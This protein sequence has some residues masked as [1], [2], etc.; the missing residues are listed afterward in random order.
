MRGRTP[1]DI[2]LSKATQLYEEYRVLKAGAGE[3]PEKLKITQKWL[4]KRC[5]DYRISLKYP[6]KRFSV[7]QEVQKRRIT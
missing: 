2:L 6:S 5:K 3:E 1:Q 7:T 4:Q